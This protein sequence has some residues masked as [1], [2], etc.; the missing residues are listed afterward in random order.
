MAQIPQSMPMTDRLRNRIWLS[1]TD[2]MSPDANPMTRYRPRSP[3]AR[4]AGSAS[5]PPMGS[6]TRSTPVP[7]A[8][9]RA[10]SLIGLG[11]RVQSRFRTGI[12][13]R[14]P[15]VRARCHADHPAAQRPRHS[16]GGQPDATARSENQHGLTGRCV[17]AVAQSEEA[18]AVA[19]GEG[20]GPGSVHAFGQWDRRARCHHDPAGVAAQAHRGQHPV[21]DGRRA[22]VRAHLH[23]V[24][25]HLAAGD[26]GERGLDLVLPGHEKAVHEVHPGRLDRHG[27]L[28]RAGL[29]VGPLLHSQDGGR[30]QLMANGG[31]HGSRR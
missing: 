24:P 26:E 11:R 5:A 28:A 12:E 20:R 7:P 25:G 9:A 31:T 2:G 21:A 4:S 22:D 13:C 14:L 17:G 18:C 27:H 1:G 15:L 8:Q 10:A 30:S 19:L 3:S 6:T 16:D 23:D 29:G